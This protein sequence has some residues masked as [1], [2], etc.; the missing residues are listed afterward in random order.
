MSRYGAGGSSTPSITC[1][2]AFEAR[3]EATTV[4]SL[5]VALAS[6]SRARSA[7]IARVTARAFIG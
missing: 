5:I 2:E 1:T 3:T 7:P 4:A 6:H